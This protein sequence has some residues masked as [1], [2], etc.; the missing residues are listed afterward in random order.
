MENENKRM[1]RS[2]RH[3][4]FWTG[5]A[6]I[7]IGGFLLARKTGVDFPD[8]FFTWPMVLILAGV[9]TGI[10]HRFQNIS[11]L[12][13]LAIGGFFLADEAMIDWNMKPYFWPI[14][15]IG[16]GVAFI[17][18]P[19]KRWHREK[20]SW[21]EIGNENINVGSGPTDYS[22]TDV[23]ESVSVFG[24]VKRIVTSKNFKGGEI[25]CFMGGAEYNFSQADITGPVEI[26]IVQGFAG[27]KLIVPP[28]WEIRS[29][30]VA[31][32][33]GIEDKRHAQPGTFDPNKILIIKGVTIFGGI[34]IKSY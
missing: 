19:K 14:L 16:V 17:L 1:F 20:Q 26:E 28:H 13:M 4:K 10:K 15:I 33:A 23:I 31:I 8:W 34:E 22:S 5:L 7:I 3:D 30:F 9:I 21:G 32:F 29:E 6:F 12:I 2:E 25:I 24:G 27:T 11:W 18:R